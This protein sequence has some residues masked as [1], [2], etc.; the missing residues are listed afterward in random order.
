MGR[1]DGQSKLIIQGNTGGCHKLTRLTLTGDSQ[2]GPCS[3]GDTNG[4]RL[5]VQEGRVGVDE[6]KLIILG[7]LVFH[8]VVNTILRLGLSN[9][10]IVVEQL[11]KAGHWQGGT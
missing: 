7:T 2:Q 11:S 10:I 9:I 1:L 6:D 3:I 8:C 4:N 5:L